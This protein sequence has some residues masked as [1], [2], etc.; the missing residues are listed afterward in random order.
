MKRGDRLVV[1][2]GLQRGQGDDVGNLAEVLVLEAAGRQR[3][4]A[5]P[6]PEVTIGGRRSLGTAL[7]LT[8]MPMV[9]S[10]SSACRPSS[11]ESTRS[12]GTR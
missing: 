11:T 1:E 10:R 7:R 8:V 6:Q 2:L 3:R 5:D 4:G 9:C 12:T